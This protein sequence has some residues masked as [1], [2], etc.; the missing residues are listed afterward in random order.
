VADFFIASFSPHS[1]A[2]DRTLQPVPKSL[3]N[4]TSNTFNIPS[5]G[6]IP[7]VSENNFKT[8]MNNQATV[9]GARTVKISVSGQVIGGF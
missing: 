2:L 3:Y 7:A 1:N 6:A 8:W 5:V 4:C 9:A